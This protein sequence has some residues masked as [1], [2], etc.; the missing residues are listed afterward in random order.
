MDLIN[1]SLLNVSFSDGNNTNIETGI[2][3]CKMQANQFYNNFGN[4]L[5]WQIKDYLNSSIMVAWCEPL[6]LSIVSWLLSRFCCILNRSLQWLSWNRFC[7]E[8]KFYNGLVIFFLISSFLR[9]RVFVRASPSLSPF[10]SL[11]LSVFLSLSKTLHVLSFS[12]E[13]NRAN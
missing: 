9:Q 12:V 13:L 11:V 10:L 3:I 6:R 5:V 4:Y 1:I 7:F 2:N 8:C